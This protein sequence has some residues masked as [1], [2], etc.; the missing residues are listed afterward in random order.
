[1]SK[2]NQEQRDKAAEYL[3]EWL[4]PGDTVYT[5]VRHVSRSGMLRHI[6]LVVLRYDTKR[7]EINAYQA[8]YNAALV[9]GWRVNKDRDALIVEGAGMD[10]GFH[11]V[12]ELSHVLFNDG[13]A[14]NQRWL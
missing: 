14:L 11:T 3:K 8:S 1:M 6:G 13:Y 12:Y 9:L 2:V 4:K 10:M 5:I 7:K